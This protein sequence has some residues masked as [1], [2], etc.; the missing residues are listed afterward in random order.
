M[1]RS[2]RKI[3]Y[4][5]EHRVKRKL[6]GRIWDGHDGDVD[7][8]GFRIECKARTGLRLESTTTL[9]DWMDQIKRYEDQNPGIPY[10][11]A[12]T[13]TGNYQRGRIWVA[14]DIDNF[15]NLTDPATNGMILA[16]MERIATLLEERTDE[17]G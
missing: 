11:L 14:T 3:G 10:A 12:F 15:A 16:Q 5:F 8:R 6:E 2:G 9:R 17:H 4:D 13:G 1:A 7:A